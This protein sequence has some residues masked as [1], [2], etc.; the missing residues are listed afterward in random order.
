MTLHSCGCNCPKWS[1]NVVL[2]KFFL[3]EILMLVLQ[4]TCFICI[5]FICITWKRKQTIEK[6]P[7][8]AC[9][10]QKQ[11]QTKIKIN[12]ATSYL[13][14]PR[15]LLFNLAHKQCMVSLKDGF[16]VWCQG[17]KEDFLP[18]L[19]YSINQEFIHDKGNKYNQFWI[20]HINKL[21]ILL[22]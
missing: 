20:Y 16:T 7:H 15:V 19:Y 9:G 1:Q 21:S 14:W 13:K 8:C 18:V 22:T 10:E 2:K 11:N 6:Q 3:L 17:Q 12:K 4:S 5:C